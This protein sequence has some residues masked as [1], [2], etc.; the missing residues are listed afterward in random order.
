MSDLGTHP[1]REFLCILALVSAVM[2]AIYVWGPT[3]VEML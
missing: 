1:G 3:I 2:M